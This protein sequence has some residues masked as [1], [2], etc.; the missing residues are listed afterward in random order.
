MKWSLLELRKY[1]DEPL[2]FSQTIDLKK[3]LLERDASILDIQ[4][5]LIDGLV[6]VSKAEYIVHYTVSTTIT[7]PSTR[8][9]TPVSLPLN[10][11]VDEVFMTPE[12]YQQRNDLIPEEDILILENDML[13]LYESV[14][15][16]ILLAIP[17]QVLTE[18]EVHSTE[19]PKGEGWEVI[20]EEDYLQRETE[21]A[22]KMDRSCLEAMGRTGR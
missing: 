16:N 4:P 19:F 7:V 1:Q 15:D 21:A 9:L 5:I 10:F 8:S 11:M 6:T 13:D 12:Q 18:E 14:E 2:T 3:K 20:S 17:T 22:P